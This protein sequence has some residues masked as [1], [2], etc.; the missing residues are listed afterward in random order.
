MFLIAY[1]GREFKFGARELNALRATLFG[2]LFALGQTLFVVSG[3]C[4]PTENGLRALSGGPPPGRDPIVPQDLIAEIRHSLPESKLK[5][6]LE[7]IEETLDTLPA[8]FAEGEGPALEKH[9]GR[10]FAETLLRA[11]VLDA[12]DIGTAAAAE[13]QR[14]N[15][16]EILRTAL[17]VAIRT[18]YG[19]DRLADSFNSKRLLAYMLVEVFTVSVAIIGSNY[20]KEVGTLQ[21]LVLAQAIALA[22]ILPVRWFFR[23]VKVSRMDALMDHFW[24]GVNERGLEIPDRKT[25]LRETLGIPEGTTNCQILLGLRKPS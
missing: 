13:E 2:L 4:D 20:Y 25:F 11:R 16:R 3:W 22:A 19:L 10:R 23:T 8:S 15:A 12:M 6:E 18:Q 1:V 17:A 9:L 7:R 21:S 5:L 14:E 24:K